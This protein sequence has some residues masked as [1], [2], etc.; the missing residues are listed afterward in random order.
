[1]SLA[2]RAR[3]GEELLTIQGDAD[4]LAALVLVT[5]SFDTK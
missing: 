4:D 1:M 3:A 2:L 5:P